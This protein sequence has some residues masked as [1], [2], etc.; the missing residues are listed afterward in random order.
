MIAVTP[1]LMSMLYSALRATP[2]FCRWKL[3]PASEL[4]F[5]VSRSVNELGTHEFTEGTHIIE[6]SANKNST[7]QTMIETMA[8]EMVHV[9]EYQLYRKTAH[10][11]RFQKLA[12]AVC[13]IHGFDPKAF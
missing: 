10:G 6:L 3:P 1:N 5:K 13:K 12:E 2:P 9:R 11:R 8:H 7:L 4:I